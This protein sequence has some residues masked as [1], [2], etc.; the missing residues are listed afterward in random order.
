MWD[1]RAKLISVHDGDT[2]TMEMDTGFHGRQ[3]EHLR[4]LGTFAPELST[5]GGQETKQF[6]ISW[7]RQWMDPKLVWPFYIATEKNN[8]TEPQ[9]IQTLARYV[10]RIWDINKKSC[11]NDEINA[12]LATHPEWGHGIGA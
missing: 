10:A 2:V 1:Y 8:S 11:L 12:F 6:V 9:E 7:I 5:P 4:L 3:E